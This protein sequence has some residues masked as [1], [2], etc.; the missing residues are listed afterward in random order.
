[1]FAKP[2]PKKSLLPP[3]SKKRK[4]TS[5]VEEVTFDNDARH[6]YLTGFHKRKQQRIKHAQEE[7]AKRERQE[8]LETRKQVPKWHDICEG[9][10]T[11]KPCDRR[12]RIVDAKWR[13]MSRP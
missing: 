10:P 2:R 4:T 6:E 3:P 13:S 9:P 8:K 11:N 5:T 7:A 1:M 12:A